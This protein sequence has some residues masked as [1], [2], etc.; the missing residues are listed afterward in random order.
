M[1]SEVLE[2]YPVTNL[3]TEEELIAAA[4]AEITKGSTLHIDQKTFVKNATF[5]TDGYIDVYF[6]VK[7]GSESGLIY[8]RIEIPC[9]KDSQK[10]PTDLPLNKEEWDIVRYTNRERYTNGLKPLTITEFLQSACDMR[11]TDMCICLR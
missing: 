8:K 2:Y 6:S 10:M 5:E 9:F 3:T 1:I 4:K 11:E 7:N